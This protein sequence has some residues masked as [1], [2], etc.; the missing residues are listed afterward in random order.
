MMTHEEKILAIFVRLRGI[1]K[2]PELKLKFMRRQVDER[3]RGVLNLKNSYHL[4]YVNLKNQTITLDIYTP[5]YRRPKSI[6][7]ILRILAHEIAHIQKPP[8]K[9]RWRG[10]VITRQHYPAFYQ[11]VNENIEKI[12]KDFK[13]SEYFN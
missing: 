5:R 1:F 13:L 8:F 2:L 12:K 3:G 7:S 11:Q 4:A 9:Q 6:N 10:R